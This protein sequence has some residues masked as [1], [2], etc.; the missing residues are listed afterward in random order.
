MSERAQRRE[1]RILNGECRAPSIV[2]W[3]AP[4]RSA[5]AVQQ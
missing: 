3:D 2:V 5:L 1:V 4:E